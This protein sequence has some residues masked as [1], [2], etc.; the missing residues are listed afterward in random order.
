MELS[1]LGVHPNQ[2]LLIQLG[3]LAWRRDGAWFRLHPK[4][5]K[6]WS[7]DKRRY[8]AKKIK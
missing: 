1:D 6:C 4:W 3:P 7:R 5:W 8:R 2:R